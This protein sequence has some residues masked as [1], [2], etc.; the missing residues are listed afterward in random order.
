MTA[1]DPGKYGSL[2][3]HT[4][5]DRE[6]QTGEDLDHASVVRPAEARRAHGNTLHIGVELLTN[7]LQDRL[8]EGVAFMA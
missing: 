8:R 5:D 1:D 6:Y 2:Y 3:I 4:Q 7:A